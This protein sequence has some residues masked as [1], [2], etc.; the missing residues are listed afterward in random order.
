MQLQIVGLLQGNRQ[1]VLIAI[2]LKAKALVGRHLQP[3]SPP[4]PIRPKASLQRPRG[5]LHHLDLK[6]DRLEQLLQHSSG[7]ERPGVIRNGGADD[8]RVNGGF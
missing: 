5:D 8:G 7:L 4:G 3:Q 1:P 2:A 6:P